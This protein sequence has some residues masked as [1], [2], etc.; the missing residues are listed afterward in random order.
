MKKIT[1]AFLMGCT[2]LLSACA[3]PVKPTYVSPTQ[4]QA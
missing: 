4:Y 2:L 1:I 3:T